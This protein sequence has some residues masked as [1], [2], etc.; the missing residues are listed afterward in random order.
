MATEP[1][2]F[3]GAPAP[4]A[5]QTRPTKSADEMKA[6]TIQQF[7]RVFG[8][9]G[10][11]RYNGFYSEEPNTEWRDDRRG[12]LVEEMRR[13]DASVKAVLNAVKAPILSTSWNVEIASEDPKMQEMRQYVEK[14]LMGMQRSWKDFLREALGY[15]D[16]GFY[17]FELLWEKRADGFITVYDLAPRIP[18]SVFKWE[19]ADKRF[20]IV[21]HIRT[22]IE[23]LPKDVTGVSGTLEIPAEKLLILTNDKEGDDVTGQSILRAAFQHYLRKK[24]LYKIAS[25][26]AERY[27]VGIPVITGPGSASDED[28]SKGEEL[29]AQIRS[30]EKNF[31]YF[32]NKDW[33]IK[34]LTPAGNPQGSAIEEMVQHHNKQI[35]LAV[36]ATF[37]GLGTDSTG[38]FALS[39]DQSGFFL[40]HV[41]DKADYLVEQIN[42]QVIKRIVDLNYGPQEIYP[43]LKY[44]PLGDIDYQELSGALKTL[45]DGGLVVVDA[46][47]KQWVHRTFKLPEITEEDMAR[48]EA[49]AIDASLKTVEGD[50]LDLGG[51]APP[52]TSGMGDQQPDAGDM[53]G[54]DEGMADMNNGGDQQ[55]DGAMPPKV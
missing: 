50:A 30:N 45:V 16:F 33:E 40:K 28:K 3:A 18:R 12:D 51:E 46:K 20:G 10:T 32:D 4:G 25:I 37:L 48:M 55:G 2:G 38:S 21:Q 9:S 31:V 42:L 44:A 36:L 15:L 13:G 27:G 8:D 19:L 43:Q 35:L 47:L 17:C 39:Q 34:I 22:S 11:E 14:S 24:G 29:G 53:G 6:M 26:A 23:N 54:T 1:M 52:D 41:Q 7:F 49:E 5:V